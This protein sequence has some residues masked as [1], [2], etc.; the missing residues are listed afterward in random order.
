MGAWLPVRDAREWFPVRLI[1][2]GGFAEF[3]YMP[4]S[5]AV[6]H[7]ETNRDKI[8]KCKSVFCFY[9]SQLNNGTSGVI[10]SS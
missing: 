9:A 2:T 3:P 4:G 8:S 1:K 6:A 10:L 5:S 7:R